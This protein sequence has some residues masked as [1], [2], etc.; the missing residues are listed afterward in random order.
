MP[1]PKDNCIPLALL[2]GPDNPAPPRWMIGQSGPCVWSIS[3]WP[4]PN[5][6]VRS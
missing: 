2:D 1:L 4:R 3:L 5:S 6:E